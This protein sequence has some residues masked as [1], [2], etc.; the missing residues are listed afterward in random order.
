MMDLFGWFLPPAFGFAIGFVTNALAIRMLFRPHEEV[1]IL[2]L[3]F[4]GMVPRRQAEIARTVSHTV[5]SE[6]LKEQRVAQR[7]TGPEVTRALADLVTTVAGAYLD[8][9]YAALQATLSPGRLQEVREALAEVLVEGARAVQGWVGTEEGQEEVRAALRALAERPLADY[10]RGEEVL[11]AKVLVGKLAQALASPHME[12][13]VRATCAEALVR[14]AGS[15]KPLGS[16][17]PGEARAA[18]DA[19]ARQL[20][21]E[22]LRRFEQALLS[23]S[24]V[25]KIKRAVRCGI[26]DYLL[27]TEGGVVKN[28]VR[29][30]ALL[31]RERIFREAD[32]VVEAN[33]HRLEA[34]IRERDSREQ[35]D[36]AILEGLDAF[37]GRTP[38]ELLAAMPPAMLDALH[39]RLAGGVVQYLTREEVTRSLSR[40]VEREVARMFRTPVQSLLQGAG[41]AYG[42]LDRWAE[43]VVGWAVAGGLE[44]VARREGPRWARALTGIEIGRPSRFLPRE[45][46]GE[47]ARAAVDRLAPLLSAQVP[48]VLRIV[49]VRGLIEREILELSP[50]EVERVI[51]SVSRRELAAITWWGGVLG[52]AVG[53][54]QSLMTAL[55]P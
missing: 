51:L 2:G 7:L 53:S 18:L 28:L 3:R 34:L 26:E 11:V 21:P 46:V 8:R 9:R 41:K 17:L 43:K 49:D 35:V 29:Q 42:D 13:W 1:R 40:W 47:L 30:A 22:V 14:L 6:L 39:D 32:E 15:E 20:G 25:E 33:L 10:L 52:A 36:A 27:A 31:G 5:A 4:Q 19:A 38:A 54:L 50:R 16:Y 55:G 48:E 12:G 23:P 24:N 45:I 37:L 44:G